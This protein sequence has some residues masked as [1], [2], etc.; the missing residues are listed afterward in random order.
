MPNDT[1][2]TESDYY[3]G[4]PCFNCGHGVLEHDDEMGSFSRF[5]RMGTLAE[6]C[7]CVGYMTQEE[8]V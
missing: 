5:C 7:L 6:P 8:S 1:E 3:A 2:I 4:E